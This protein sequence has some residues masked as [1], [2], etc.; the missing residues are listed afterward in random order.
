[1]NTLDGKVTALDT[2]HEG[3]KTWTLDLGKTPMLS[4]NIHQREVILSIYSELNRI[5]IYIKLLFIFLQITPSN[6]C[7]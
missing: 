5:K 6:F 1:M 7:K 2:A 4:S 3:K